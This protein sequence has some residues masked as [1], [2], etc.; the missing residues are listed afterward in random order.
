MQQYRSKVGRIRKLL[1]WS[2]LASSSFYYRPSGAKRGRRPSTHTANIDGELFENTVVVKQIEI[3]LQQEFCCYGYHMV[4]CELHEIGWIINH[5]KVYRLMDE[6]HMLFNS[7]IKVIASQRSFV[8]Y[9]KLLPERPLQYLSMDIKFVHI[10]ASGRNA[11][12]LTVMDV[13]SRK[14]LMHMLRYNI[15]KGDVLVM[16]SLLLLEYK[17]QGMTIRNDNGSQFIAG[18]VRQF[19]KDKGVYQEFSHVGTPEDNAYIEALHS[20]LQREVINRFEFDSIYHAALVIDRY[21]K[22]YNEKRRHGSLNRRRP[23]EIWDQ[24]FSN[25]FP[26]K[27]KNPILQMKNTPDLLNHFDKTLQEIGV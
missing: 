15:R 9:R 1:Q 21:Y 3:I 20:N 8:R 10:H 14:V 25:P 6:H 19:L 24:Y 7:R 5:K 13:Y 26:C 17:P 12:L 18:A 16:L 22:W 4:T 23:Q 27:T 2:G 11:L